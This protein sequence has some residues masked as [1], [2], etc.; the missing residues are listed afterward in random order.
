[1]RPFYRTKRSFYGTLRILF[2][3]TALL[4]SILF[5][6]LFSP[7]LVQ[8]NSVANTEKGLADTLLLLLPATTNTTLGHK[9]I[10]PG[11]FRAISSDQDTLQEDVDYKLDPTLGLLTWMR[12]PPDSLYLEYRY[13]PVVLIDTLQHQAPLRAAQVDSLLAG[14]ELSPSSSNTTFQSKGRFASNLRR[15]GHILRGVQVGSGRDVSLESGLHLSLDG[16]LAQDI[17]VKAL[18]DDRTLP[19]QPEGTSRRLDELDQVYVDVTAGRTRGRFGDYRLNFDAGRYGRIDRRL[20]G[21]MIETRQPDWNARAAGAVTRA[22]FHTNQFTGSD[23]VQGPYRLTGRNGELNLIVIGGSERV[24]VDG[25]ERQRGEL[26]DYTIDYN[27]GEITFTPHLPITSESRIEIDFEYSPE[28]FPRNL[29]AGQ[30]GYTSPSERFT[31]VANVAFEGDDPDRPLAFDMTPSIRSALRDADISSGYAYVPSADS[32]GTNQGDYHRADTTWTD[33]NSYSIF[34]FVDPADNGDPRGEWQVVFSEVSN[35]QGDYERTYDALLG[36][37]RYEWVGPGQGDWVAARR[38]P[39]PE[40][41]RNAAI[42]MRAEPGRWLVLG[43]DLGASQYDPNTVARGDGDFGA[44]QSYTANLKPWELE[45]G[46]IPLQ[47]DLNARSEQASYRS[48]ARTRA[49]EFD[50]TWGLDSLSTGQNEDELGAR[51]TLRP[52]TSTSIEGGFGSLERS[53]PDTATNRTSFSSQRWDVAARHQRERL[54]LNGHFESIHSDRD[55]ASSNYTSDWERVSANAGYRLGSAFQPTLD[56]E[57]EQRDLRYLQDPYVDFAGHRYR[58]W[59]A[60][61]NLLPLNGHTGTL[62][63]QQRYRDSQ[64]GSG[65]YDALYDE[66]S[67]GGQWSWKPRL[68]PLRGDLELNHSVKNFS[69]ADSAD[70]TSDLASLHTGWSPLNG[71]LTSDLNYRLSR[72]VTRPSV[73]IAYPVPVGQGDYIRVDDEYVYDPEIGDIILRPEPTGDALPTTDL[74]AALNLDWS[75][76]RLPNGRGDIDGFGWEDISLVTQLEAQEITRWDQSSDIYLLRLGNFQTDSTVT[77]RLFLRQEMYL[78]RPSRVFNLRLRYEGEKRLTNLYLTGAERYGR[79]AWDLRTRNALTRDLDMENEAS[80][81]RRSKNFARRNSVDR[82]VLNR[83]SSQ[84]S[85]RLSS[86]WRISWQTRGLLDRDITN[87]TD[88]QGLGLKPGITMAL[89]E[90]GRIS[91]EFESL[92]IESPIASIPYDLADGRPPGRNGRGNLRA[93]YRLGSNMTG[94]AVYTVR[95]DQGRTPIHLA[96]VEVNAFF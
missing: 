58:R 68:L 10:D 2:A 48:F 70:V 69:V 50:R 33:G 16:R 34:H 31:L 46:R 91:L 37:Y 66:W 60:N 15:S 12:P 49:T 85:Y 41:R 89:R 96:R 55:G 83:I 21:G 19:I 63:Y 80:Y 44:A 72:T 42:S 71:A 7:H 61:W 53:S 26:S 28:A 35:G 36:N 45:T 24:Y 43:A 84:L 4:V 76:H 13:L 77:G 95:L 74:A 38:L 1:M 14:Q 64:V 94:R 22:L 92:W 65:L 88:V 93:D 57:L 73:L 62:F 6:G 39:L 23:G 78:F 5:V 59:R 32:L 8:A 30:T 47:I 29:Y 54:T 79:D 56:G 87:G 9:Y 81:E 20:E 17:E 3:E 18:L 25:I 90:K 40:Q 27:R 86:V 11:T 82:F 67:T 52:T 51:F 75:P